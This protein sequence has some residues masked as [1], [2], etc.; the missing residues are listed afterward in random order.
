MA[1]LDMYQETRTP[2]QPTHSP[3]GHDGMPSKIGRG[4]LQLSSDEWTEGPQGQMSLG[5]MLC[6]AGFPVESR[7]DTPPSPPTGP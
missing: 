6:M 7:E 3:Q 4:L 1:G 5:D 2:V